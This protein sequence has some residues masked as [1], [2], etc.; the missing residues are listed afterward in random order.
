MAKLPGYDKVV[1]KMAVLSS[2]A[3]MNKISVSVIS[4]IFVKV[5]S[6]ISSD[7]FDVKALMIKLCICPAVPMF[8]LNRTY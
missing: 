5:I 1:L 8:A 6:E 4:R 3:S 7:D 2:P